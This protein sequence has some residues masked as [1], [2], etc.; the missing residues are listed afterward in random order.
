MRFKAK[1]QPTVTSVEELEEGPI[2]P[3]CGFFRLWKTLFWKHRPR[4]D[5]AVTPTVVES[6]VARRL[7]KERGSRSTG[8]AESGAGDYLVDVTNHHTR[9]LV[10][11]IID[12]T[13]VTVDE[14]IDLLLDRPSTPDLCL[15][16]RIINP[17]LVDKMLLFRP[18]SE[19][20]AKKISQTPSL[21]SRHGLLSDVEELS[22][23]NMDNIISDERLNKTE[24]RPAAPEQAEF[25][26]YD[27][28]MDR[29]FE[30]DEDHS[31]VD[32]SCHFRDSDSD[33]IS[34]ESSS[35]KPDG[36]TWRRP[37]RAE[38]LHDWDSIS[39]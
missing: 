33:A 16:G 11:R 18:Y 5:P 36:T 31:S 30:E 19:L 2:K 24:T 13:N 17:R 3:S 38:T 32:L 6:L 28:P 4:V 35:P 25:I 21:E 9:F 20:S 10:D 29:P 39:Q 37:H 8:M 1:K 14:E 7:P 23:H 26:V 22:W 27:P 34:W 12:K 15:S